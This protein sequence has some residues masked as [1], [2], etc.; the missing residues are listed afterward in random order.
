M[1]RIQAEERWLAARAARMSVGLVAMTTAGIVLQLAVTAFLGHLG[2]DALYV[3]SIYLPFGFVSLAVSEG[4]A[5][6]VQVSASTLSQRGDTTRIGAV[7][8]LMTALS[9][10]G[11]GALALVVLAL[12]SPLEALLAVPAASRTAV[13]AF[14]VT[15]IAVNGLTML[16][17]LAAAALRGLGHAGTAAWLAAGATVVTIGAI[18]AAR[19]LWG[20]GAMSVPVGLTA[21][22]VPLGLVSWTAL[23]RHGVVLGRVADPAPALRLLQRVA[24][25]VAGSFLVLSVAS[26]GYLWLLRDDGV[27]AVTGFALG[28][29]VQTFLIV[30]AIAIGSAVAIAV[31]LRGEAGQ[32]EAFRVLLRLAL[33]AYAGIAGAVFLLRRPLVE[34]LTGDRAVGQVAVHYLGV[35]GPSLLPLGITLAL[36][37]YL[38]QTGRAMAAFVLNATFF[39]VVLAIGA[40]FRDPLHVRA[41]VVLI[42]LANVAGCGC[43][44]VSVHSLLRIQKGTPA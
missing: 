20:L 44:A 42:A 32:Q 13:L 24:L 33:P 16:P 7:L 31:T 30:P 15:V 37:T 34:L 1:W 23:C 3:R 2:G 8:T 28:Q 21:A 19:Q 36:L 27:A 11:F 12:A 6:A 18:G 22:S 10:G 38:E 29:T 41:L 17:T 40:A 39:T 26:F 14:L 35:V 5:V 4:V 25:P 43:V 9:A